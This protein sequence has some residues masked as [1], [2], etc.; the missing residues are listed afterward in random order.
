[1]GARCGDAPAH[2][3]PPYAPPS[4]PNVSYAGWVVDAGP[5]W[6]GAGADGIINCAGCAAGGG[7]PYAA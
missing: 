4:P 2:P 3:S 7:A 6:K 5:S 1:M